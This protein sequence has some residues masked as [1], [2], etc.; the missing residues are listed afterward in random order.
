MSWTFKRWINQAERDV[1]TQG[2][3]EWVDA[4]EVLAP[5]RVPGQA[6][7]VDPQ[8]LQHLLIQA[9]HLLQPLVQEVQ[10]LLPSLEGTVCTGRCGSCKEERKG[11]GF[12]RGTIPG[13]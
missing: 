5:L 3:V 12:L 11:A 6:A 2:D 1:G 7:V 10:T 8:G 4:K 13:E 9:H